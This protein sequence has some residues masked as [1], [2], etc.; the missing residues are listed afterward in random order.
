MAS[1]EQNA[2]SH[3]SEK[4]LT[5]FAKMSAEE[6]VEYLLDSVNKTQQLWGLCGA[7]GWTMLE[8]D[9]V[10]CLPLWPHAEIANLWK[11]KKSITS[12]PTLIE[13]DTFM[14]VWIPGLAK[15]QTSLLLSPANSDSD[16]VMTT[17]EFLLSIK[18]A[19]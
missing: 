14:N 11:D 4:Q 17:E 8:S 2:N 7:D 3:L 18:E 16:I 6:R 19:N 10:A 15:N 1:I 5:E 13:L 9:G 12:E